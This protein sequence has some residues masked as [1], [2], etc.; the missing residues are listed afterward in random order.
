MTRFHTRL[1]CWLSLVLLAGCGYTLVGRG[2]LPSHIATIAIPVFENET[3]QEGIEDVF[4]QAVID[5]YVSGGKLRLVS[6]NEADAVLRGTIRGYDN[7]QALTYNDQNNVASYKLTVSVDIELWDN[8]QDEVF[9]QTENLTEE[10]DFAGGPDVK[11]N[12]QQ[13]N[14]EAALKRLAKDL[15][16]RIFAL[17]TEGF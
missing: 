4:T 12:I 1:L 13:E 17:S 6:E 7:T 11:I 14:A 16:E 3:L 15:A 9:W 10:D 2:S 8:I 5:V